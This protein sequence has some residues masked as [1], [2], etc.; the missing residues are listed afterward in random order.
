MSSP[1]DK[2]IYFSVF[3]IANNGSVCMLVPVSMCIYL[4]SSLGHEIPKA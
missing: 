4:K 2:D 3:V 1:K